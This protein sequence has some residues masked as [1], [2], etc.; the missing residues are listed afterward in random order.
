MSVPYTNPPS[1]APGARVA[2]I[3]PA[4]P[5][6]GPD[7]LARAEQNARDL[8]WEPHTLPHAMSRDGY[9]AGDDVS[10]LADLN[11][12]I[13]DPR[14][15]GIWCVRGGYGVMR[16]LEGVDYDSLRR[17]PKSII[18]FSDITALHLAVR[19]RADIVSYHGPNARAVLT[20]FSRESRARAPRAP[21][22]RLN[23]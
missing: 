5:L 22:A 6:A 16:I 14:I 17:A 1:L 7:D 9:L 19:A 20:P 11:A 18:G 10:R 13:R 23:K 21:R 2:L 15:D 8:G 4:G 3:S 12:A